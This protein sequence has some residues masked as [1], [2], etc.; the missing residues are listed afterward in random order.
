MQP[1]SPIHAKNITTFEALGEETVR[2]HLAMGLIAE[3][4]KVTHAKMWLED[5]DRARAVAVEAE[6]DRLRQ[7]EI[8]LAERSA[9]AGEDAVEV[10]RKANRVAEGANR[11]ATWALIVAGF[12]AVIAVCA[13]FFG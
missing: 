11:I 8:G 9:K 5:R 4:K 10:A 1:M 6:A 7:V 12:G 3:P 13:L 2:S